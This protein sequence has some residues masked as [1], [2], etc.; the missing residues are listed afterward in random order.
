MSQQTYAVLRLIRG[1]A[2][3]TNGNSLVYGGFPL[4]GI[5]SS[6][7][8]PPEIKMETATLG[9]AETRDLNRDPEVAAF[10][11][12]MPTALFQPLPSVAAASAWGITAVKGDTSPWTGAGVTVAVLDTGIDSTHPA[13]AG[14]TL[15]QKDFT[16]TGDGDGHG[17]GTH[18][19]GTVFGRPVG[20]TRIGV[21]P[22]VTR[23]LIGKVLGTNGAGTSQGIFEAMQW[24]LNNGAHVI[25]MSLGFDFPGMVKQLEGQGIPT[26]PSVSQALEAYRANLRMFDALMSIARA[27]TGFGH[28]SVIVAATG[29]ES[30]RPA[31]EVAVSVP[32]AAEGVLAVG[33]IGQ[34]NNGYTV[35]SFSNTNPN[36]VAPGVDVLSA[37]AGGGT[38]TMSGTSMATPHVAGVAALWWEAILAKAPHANAPAV[39]AKLRASARSDVFAAGLDPVDRGDGL[40]TAPL[41]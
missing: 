27:Q 33:A 9:A 18:C 8:S 14:V 19:A 2:P 36:V 23:A 22:G 12:V 40:V 1:A 10:A 29:N 6:P 16:G 34:A 21:A 28:G 39:L 31:W 15:D 25:S 41:V 32:A 20:G 24:A 13:F 26:V 17:H 3:A 37:R 7:P 11:R 5:A 35:A 4:A 30:N 38:V